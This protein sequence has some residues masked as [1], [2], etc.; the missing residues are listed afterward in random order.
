[1]EIRV[2]VRKE[3]VC[4][5]HSL[6]CI[7]FNAR[8]I[9][10]KVDELKAWTDTWGHDIVTISETWLQEGQDWQL[11]I[12]GYICFRCDRAG[13]KKGGGVALL[14]KED[15]TAVRWQDGLEGSSNEAVWVKLRGEG[16][17]RVLIGVYYRP[18]NGPRK[19][20]EQICRE[21]MYMCENHK[22]VIMGDFNFPH[23]DWD[24][25]TVR[26]LHGLEFD[27]VLNVFDC[28]LNQLVEELTRDGVILD[29]LLGN[30]L[31]QV[32]DINVGEQIGS[33]DHNYVSFRV[34][35]GKCKEGPKVEVLD[36]RRANFKGIRRDLG[37]IEWDRIFS[38]KDVNEKLRI[39]KKEILRLQSSYVPVRIKGKAG[40]HREAWFSRN[41]GNLVKRKREVYKKYKEQGAESL[42]EDYKECRRN[43]KKEI[44]KAKKRHEEALADRVKINLKG[45]SR[46]IKSKRLVR[47]K[48][49]PL[50][51]SEGRL[52]E[53]SKEMGEI[54]NDF[55]ASV[56]TREKNIE[57]V[58]VKKNSGKVMKHI[59]ITEEVVMAVLK[60]IKV[61]K[62]PGPDRIFPREYSQGGLCTDS[63]AIN[64]DI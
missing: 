22:V 25:H 45:F 27:C 1:M 39:F 36:W 46:Y 35:L 31:G 59:R 50:V 11:N 3:N 20:E 7:Y 29:L 34:V 17:M 14:V 19:L 48:I 24:T 23:I 37:S 9:V 62:S 28:I 42:K 16:G 57:P 12:P 4:E 13:G 60:K 64:R 2:E 30:E 44:R 32:W 5:D 47:D 63:G 52:S 40:S 21:I 33:R 41:I 49:G 61:D 26:G 6:K 51:D 53:K 56:F 55:F 15:I 18:P 10:N 58:E 43:L 38:G 8:S 54:L